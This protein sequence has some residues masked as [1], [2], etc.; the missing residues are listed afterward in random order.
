MRCNTLKCP[1]G[2]RLT[3][4]QAN[5]NAARRSLPFRTSPPPCRAVPGRRRAAC[6]DTGS[7]RERAQR[8]RPARGGCAGLT[9]R[10]QTQTLPNWIVSGY[11]SAPPKRN[12]W[13]PSPARF[14][15]PLAGSAGP[16]RNS[17]G[18]ACQGQRG[19]SSLS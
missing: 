12:S 6:R 10:E 14:V 7:C 5:T 1:P 17:P 3:Q 11:S 16:L 2:V 9:G 8:P 18:A 13:C 4:G 15:R 19:F